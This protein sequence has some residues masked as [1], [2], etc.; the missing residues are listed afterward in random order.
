VLA[1]GDSLYLRGIARKQKQALSSAQKVPL[2]YTN[3]A[4]RNWISFQ[5][6]GANSIYAP[7]SY[8][9]YM[10]LDLPVSMVAMNA[11]GSPRSL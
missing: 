6:V 7:G 4:L 8:H 2:L 1:R 10:N 3:V 5:K 11:R 9:T